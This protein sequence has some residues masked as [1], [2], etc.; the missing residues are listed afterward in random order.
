M[1]ARGMAAALAAALICLSA[2][3]GAFAQDGAHAS[4]HEAMERGAAAHGAMEHAPGG[5]AAGMDSMP[6][7]GHDHEALMRDAQAGGLPVGVTERLGGM[8]PADA[9]FTDSKGARVRLGDLFDRPT[10]LLPV[11]Y[12]CPNVCHI[13]QSSFAR[14]LPQ[15]ALEPGTEIQVVSLSFDDRDT[16]DNA[17]R[18]KRNFTTALDGGFPPEHWRFLVGDAHNIALAMDALGFGFRRVGDDFAHPVIVAALAPGGKIVRYLYGSDFLP[19]DVTMA[20]TEAARGQVG[21][22][23]KRVLSYCFS[24]DPEGRR[25]TFNLMRVAGLS[26]LGFLAVV[27]TVLFMTGARRRGRKP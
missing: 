6:Q 13:L 23:V 26:V 3:C 11:Y 18:A 25:Y 5:A 16:V 22:S 9:V 1:G 27:M 14:V 12:T 8:M 7:G 21:L 17:A 10:I 4:G 19:F 15:V 20:A 2:A 24:Y